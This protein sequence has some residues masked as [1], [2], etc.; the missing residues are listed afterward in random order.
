[1]EL[2][3][4]YEREVEVISNELR[5][6]GLPAPCRSGDDEEVSMMRL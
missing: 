1:M 5:D 6:C 3:A 4:L 2:V